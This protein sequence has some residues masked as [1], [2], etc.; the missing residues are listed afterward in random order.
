MKSELNGSCIHYHCD[1]K[2]KLFYFFKKVINYLRLLSLATAQLF[3]Q[4]Y[5]SMGD[6]KQCVGCVYMS[7]IF[8]YLL[9]VA[10]VYVYLILRYDFC[11]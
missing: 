3:Y 5:E 7:V 2:K 1:F 6:R 11:S 9:H 4:I 10:T 8:C